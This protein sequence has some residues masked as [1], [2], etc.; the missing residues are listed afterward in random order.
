MFIA[1]KRPSHD[2]TLAL[3]RVFLLL[4]ILNLYQQVDICSR[5]TSS[6]GIIV[7]ATEATCLLNN[8]AVHVM[9]KDIIRKTI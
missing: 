8:K 1:G 5:Y 2:F 9:R 7:C 6:A 3:R 4:Q